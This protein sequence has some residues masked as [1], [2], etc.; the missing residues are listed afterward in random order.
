[1]TAYVVRFCRNLRLKSSQQNDNNQV[2]V[3]PLGTEEIQDAEEYWAKEAQTG[4]SGRI[5][6]GDSKTLS[7]FTDDKGIIRVGG[8]VDSNLLSYDGKSPVHTE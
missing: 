8:R 2:Q 1:M 6:K 5:E 4:L 3:G 7:P